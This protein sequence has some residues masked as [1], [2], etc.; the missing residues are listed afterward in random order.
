MRFAPGAAPNCPSFSDIPN[1]HPFVGSGPRAASVLLLLKLHCKKEKKKEVRPPREIS[2][3]LCVN[4]DIL[5]R[6][7]PPPPDFT[8]PLSPPPTPN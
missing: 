5:L 2:P 3:H 8:C 7:P 6:T 4:K 1:D